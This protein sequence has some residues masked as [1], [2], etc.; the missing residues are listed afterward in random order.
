MKK[1]LTILVCT[2][3]ITSAAQTLGNGALD[4]FKH[5]KDGIP[6]VS[7]GVHSI[8][9][10]IANGELTP[11]EASAIKRF[12][13]VNVSDLFRQAAEIEHAKKR[14][15]QALIEDKDYHKVVRILMNNNIAIDDLNAI[16]SISNETSGWWNTWARKWSRAT[17]NMIFNA[18]S[19]NQARMVCDGALY[20]SYPNA[21]YPFNSTFRQRE[22]ARR[23]IDFEWLS[24]EELREK[25]LEIYEILITNKINAISSL[26]DKGYDEETIFHALRGNEDNGAFKLLQINQNTLDY[27]KEH[28]V[29]FDRAEFE[30]IYKQGQNFNFVPEF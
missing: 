2:L 8:D 14:S 27:L 28:I 30:K 9:E 16:V 22:E 15:V 3:I 19:D 24:A 4:N 29:D 17:H 26:E 21:I 18:D 11:M 1:F 20:M 7:S 23:D 13:G 25:A 5:T 10:K 12:M 6:F